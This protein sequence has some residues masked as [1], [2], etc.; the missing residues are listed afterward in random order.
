MA[1]LRKKNET[2]TT[3]VIAK[4]NTSTLQMRF[5]LLSG[6]APFS[7]REIVGNVAG[8]AMLNE[9]VANVGCRFI[10]DGAKNTAVL[11]SH[12]S[13]GGA[14]PSPAQ[15]AYSGAKRNSGSDVGVDAVAGIASISNA[16]FVTLYKYEM[17]E[18][19]SNKLLSYLRRWHDNCG[20][21]TSFPKVSKNWVT[22]PVQTDGVSCEL[23]TIAF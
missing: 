1:T 23:H 18:I 20:L 10:C 5:K 7:Y 17:E 11:S 15:P 22:R 9:V 12:A 3:E 2:M 4:Y 19:W 14:P 6:S 8:D 21:K 16:E 13:T